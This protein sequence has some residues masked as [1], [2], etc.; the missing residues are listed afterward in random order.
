MDIVVD[1]A[2]IV[3][4]SG[5]PELAAHLTSV[6]PV[7]QVL[8][9]E[10]D[11]EEASCVGLA[12]CEEGTAEVTMVFHA[13]LVGPHLD[14]AVVGADVWQLTSRKRSHGL[15]AHTDSIERHASDGAA[16]HGCAS[17]PEAVDPAW[18]EEEVRVLLAPI[19]NIGHGGANGSD[20]ETV[21]NG[22]AKKDSFFGGAN[23]A[24]E[25]AT[26][27][28]SALFRVELIDLHTGE[29]EINWVGEDTSKEATTHASHDVPVGA[30]STPGVRIELIV[31]E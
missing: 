29:D 11:A 1:T 23:E 14:E 9:D 31:E 16:G 7:E 5:L 22:T 30:C 18:T 19:V 2:L 15:H 12:T 8:T 17:G 13:A 28:A 3:E 27:V 10:A 21:G 6:V 24:I 4:A 26:V 20:T 25:D